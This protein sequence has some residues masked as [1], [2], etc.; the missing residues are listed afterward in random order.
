MEWKLELEALK[1]D[2]TQI[3][4]KDLKFQNEI[5]FESIL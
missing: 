1:V 4:L 3:G 5:Q 2:R